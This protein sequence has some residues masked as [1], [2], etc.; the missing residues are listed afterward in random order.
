MFAQCLSPTHQWFPLLGPILPEFHLACSY[1]GIT[2]KII[3]I[4]AYIYI[5]DTED[6]SYTQKQN[7]RLGKNAA[8]I[9][10]TDSHVA[11]MRQKLL[12]GTRQKLPYMHQK[13]LQSESQRCSGCLQPLQAIASLQHCEQSKTIVEQEQE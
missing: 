9:P 11:E 1:N 2:K 8:G 6:G 10:S 7:P 13:Y 12:S 4:C 3:I 5:L